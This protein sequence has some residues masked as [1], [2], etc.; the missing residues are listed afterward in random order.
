LDELLEQW[1][2]A[3][4]KPQAEDLCHDSPELLE[5]L[6]EKLRR[7]QRMDEKLE[8]IVQQGED[9][10]DVS[11]SPLIDVQ[12][13]GP[14]RLIEPLGHGGMGTVYKAEQ[15][16]PIKR[17]VAIKLIRPGFDTREVLARFD[18]ERQVLARLDH[19]NIAKVLDAGTTEQGRPYFVMEHVPGSPIT[20]FC[21]D[22][23]L[24]IKDRLTLFQQVCDAI[25]H[26]HT[27]AII[28]RDIKAS[29]VLAYLSDGKPMVKVI[30]FGIAKALTGERLTDATLFTESGR[31]VGTY[32]S[33]SPEQADGSPD[34]DT[35]T[36]V[37][38]LGVML[39]ELLTG[40]KPFDHAT[41]AKAADQEIKRLIREVEP[42]RPS[43]RLSSLGAEG[44]R[45]A[46]L[47]QTRLDALSKQLRSELE[48]IPLRAMRKERQRRYA[49][50]Q[51]LAED[52]SNYM[53]GKPLIAGPESKL[54]RLK[55]YS[56]RNITALATTVAIMLLIVAGTAFYIKAVR[57]GRRLAQNEQQQTA[58]ALEEVERQKAEVERRQKEAQAVIDF[59]NSD[60]FAGA[61][62]E[63]MPDKDVREE[64][65][66]K[67]LDP[68]AKAVRDRF[69]DQPEVAL[70]VMSQIGGCFERLGRSAEALAIYKD[71]L[72]QSRRMFGDDHINTLSLRNG[73]ACVLLSLGR[74]IEAEPIFKDAF[75]R[76]Q[77]LL[78][79]DHRTTIALLNNHGRSLQ[80][81]GRLVEAHLLYRDALE[82]GRR[83]LGDDA[84]ETI[85]FLANCAQVLDL[86]GRA[87]EAEPMCKE[88]MALRRRVMGPNHPDTI[89][90]TSNYASLLH[91][92][93]RQSEAELLFKEVMERF[94]DL[95]GDDHP[96]TMK[97]VSN[98]AMSLWAQG[99]ACE[100]DPLFR[101]VIPRSRRVL[102]EDHPDTLSAISNCAGVLISLDR[103]AEAVPLL[104]E[105]MDR[106]RRLLGVDHFLTIRS[107][108][109]CAFVLRSLG[110][111]TE[112]EP[113]AEEAKTRFCRVLGADHPDAMQ[114]ADNYADVLN[115]MGR[116][117]EAEP[118]FK[119]LVERRRRLLGENHPG[120]LK[121]L[122]N[123]ALVLRS[124]N[125][126]AEAATLFVD[127]LERYRQ[128]LGPD[129][130]DTIRLGGNYASTLNSL[131]R[132][133][134][135]EPLARA[136][137]TAAERSQ[138]LGPKHQITVDCAQ[139][140]AEALDAL[141]R[142]D[143]ATAVRAR[144]HL[145]PPTTQ[146]H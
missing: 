87:A 71:A 129:H 102:G 35:R 58:K 119:D 56:R 5:R 84:P 126:S 67:M 31:I 145:M 124:L 92:L 47:R 120:T 93:G 55:K 6:K 85:Q 9:N 28:H 139:V 146:P 143:E 138:S 114:A 13:I 36:D 66:R 46:E 20:R 144:F 133:A 29:N 131:C 90:S 53:G 61:T 79:E 10:V 104:R 39:Y 121:S 115:A 110:R 122:S 32:D 101:D 83:V 80:S 33:M 70:V 21:D 72:E 95:L 108:G 74:A 4:I 89:A 63:R 52:I 54:Y 140:H 59:I 60:I 48:W 49:S 11:T 34:I 78:G 42:P 57:E 94:R 81:L 27:K 86:L 118:M 44:T 50:P 51:Q 40:A 127:V 96:S 98:Y 18:S 109:N 141:G 91:S 7:L 125:R 8:R 26:A 134:E 107:I 103:A 37:Y 137:V 116:A 1:E 113:L 73:Y 17:L 68:A 132:S 75:E 106:R 111:L 16:T 38:S 130:P 12:Q 100:A 19:P 76:S 64:I 82:R 77:R 105:V 62:P 2:L 142:F 128:V 99:R 136:A 41:L 65:V 97:A 88:A 43:T 22:H 30:D 112:A 123:Y 45:F 135:A 15:R 23:R 117:V 24:S 3:D 69:K 14:Y 25:Q